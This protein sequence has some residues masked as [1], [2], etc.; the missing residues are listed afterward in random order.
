MLVERRCDWR[1]SRRITS[2]A[3]VRIERY[4][5]RGNAG[6]MKT[7]WNETRDVSSVIMRELRCGAGGPA[8]RVDLRRRGKI[9]GRRRRNGPEHGQQPDPT[10]GCA[11]ILIEPVRRDDGSEVSEERCERHEPRSRREMPVCGVRANLVWCVRVVTP[12]E[13]DDVGGSRRRK[14]RPES[15]IQSRGTGGCVYVSDV[16]R[17]GFLIEPTESRDRPVQ[18]A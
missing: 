12:R 14:L 15:Q 1:G 17:D 8:P 11:D 13:H 16:E 7:R 6:L 4:D 5:R 2:A 10:A 3:R 9:H 18:P